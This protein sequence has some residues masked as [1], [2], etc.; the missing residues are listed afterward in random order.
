MLLRK[1]YSTVFMEKILCISGPRHFK[2][3]LFKG[4]QYL[5]HVNSVSQVLTNLYTC[6]TAIQIKIQNLFIIAKSSFICL[7]PQC[8]STPGN[9]QSTFCIDSFLP[10]LD[11]I[12]M[13][14][15]YIC[16]FM[17][18]QK[19]VFFSSSIFFIA[20]QFAIV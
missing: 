6:V 15:Y 4:Q 5:F 2:P 13:D 1:Q 3:M 9:H 11:Y 12:Y 18:S 19:C 8:L 7:Y 16:S 10:I 17:S 14:L 20:E